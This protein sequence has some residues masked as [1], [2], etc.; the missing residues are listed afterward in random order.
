[1]RRTRYSIRDFLYIY[2]ISELN[3]GEPEFH[4]VDI[5]S[6]LK[7]IINAS[8]NDLNKCGIEVKQTIDSRIPQYIPVEENLFVQTM[9][10][11]LQQVLVTIGG[12]GYLS[13]NTS[14][15]VGS[16]QNGQQVNLLVLDFDMNTINNDQQFVAAIKNVERERDFKKILAA[17]NV[18]I[19]FKI[20]K[21]LCNQLGWFIEFDCFKNWRYRLTI[22]LTSKLDEPIEED[23]G[24]MEEEE[25]EDTYI[26][27]PNTGTREFSRG[28][29]TNMYRTN[30]FE[31]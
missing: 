2:D 6:S 8:Y 7:E 29:E 24:E 19:H 20:A 18:E 16:G 12:R 11:I 25:K 10:N 9:I 1:M 26:R 23:E 28:R 15:A 5:R 27:Q 13:L 3:F 21:I 30:Q 31:H 17:E 22:P 4:R 14:M